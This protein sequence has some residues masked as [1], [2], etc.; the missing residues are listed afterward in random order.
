MPKYR[1]APPNLPNNG[2]GF[3]KRRREPEMK[4]RKQIYA[5][6]EG[7]LNIAKLQD[8]PILAK[9]MGS[10]EEVDNWLLILGWVTEATPTTDAT[11]EIVQEFDDLVSIMID[12]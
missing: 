2:G 10:R 1:I 8:N 3:F 7:L 6:I 4:T 9:G 5:L 12:S 11:K